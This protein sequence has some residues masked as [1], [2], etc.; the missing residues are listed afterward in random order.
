MQEWLAKTK[1]FIVERLDGDNMKTYL[2]FLLMMVCDSVGADQGT[3]FGRIRSQFIQ[4][5]E[6]EGRKSLKTYQEVVK[7][8]SIASFENIYSKTDRELVCIVSVE[9]S[10]SKN[11]FE[12]YMAGHACSKLR[13]KDDLSSVKFSIQ[14]L[15]YKQK[16]NINWVTDVF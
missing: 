14:H 5:F 3:A 1:A 4:E 16:Q 2:F 7:V 11:K 8:V 12:V 15:S 9:G 13:K 10:K 6:I